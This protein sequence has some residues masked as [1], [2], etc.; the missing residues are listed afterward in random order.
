[1][2]ISQVIPRSRSREEASMVFI[3]EELPCLPLP[4]ACAHH[5][6]N[7]CDVDLTI[8]NAERASGLDLGSAAGR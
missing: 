8:Q 6:T 1:M 3:D 2:S 4:I 5:K 7:G